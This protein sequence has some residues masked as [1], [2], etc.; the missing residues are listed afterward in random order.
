MLKHRIT[1]REHYI[2]WAYVN[3]ER[4]MYAGYTVF[5]GHTAGCPWLAPASAGGSILHMIT[6]TLVASTLGQIINCRC[7]MEIILLPGQDDK[8]RNAAL[9]RK[10]HY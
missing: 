4:N 3:E 6:S 9:K 7:N 8:I 10:L 1:L 5:H 2:Y